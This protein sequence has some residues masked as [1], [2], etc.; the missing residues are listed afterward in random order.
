MLDVNNKVVT[1]IEAFYL[2][3]IGEDIANILQ[4][5]ERCLYMSDDCKR[6]VDSEGKDYFYNR[7]WRI[8][9]AEDVKQQLI[10]PISIQDRHLLT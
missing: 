2:S 7:I 5:K 9:M 8:I 6:W 1:D 10:M 4:N 3:A